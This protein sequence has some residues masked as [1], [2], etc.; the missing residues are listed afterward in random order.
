MPAIFSRIVH[1]AE[2]SSVVRELSWGCYY[3]IMLLTGQTRRRLLAARW[4]DF[5]FDK[6]LWRVPAPDEEAVQRVIPLSGEAVGVVR[7]FRD[8]V[9]PFGK[10]TLDALVLTSSKRKALR[11]FRKAR[12][13]LDR[14]TLPLCPEIGLWSEYD[15]RPTVER[16]LER[17]GAT[18]S[19]QRGLL[20]SGFSREDIESATPTM[21]SGGPVESW[22]AEL[23]KSVEMDRQS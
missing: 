10:P 8:A 18:R 7:P 14:R 17:A 1:E 12:L 21:T 15:L 3:R 16:G 9:T 19:F 22:G 2:S 23:M 4:S 13:W 5:D 20:G 11:D 6:R